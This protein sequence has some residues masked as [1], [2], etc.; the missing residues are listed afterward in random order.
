[1]GHL[2]LTQQLMA[3]TYPSL[4]LSHAAALKA[5]AAGIAKATAMNQPQCITVVDE[6][7]NL[8]AAVRMDGAKF[9]SI[10]SSHKKAVSAAASRAPTGPRGE[11]EVE[12]KLAIATGGRNLTLK[13]AVPILING[14]C[15]GAVGVGSGTGEQDREV[16]LAAVASIEG[17][18]TDFVFK[19]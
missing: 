1:M 3:D 11:P 7:G 5:L 13:G 19:D 6:G 18:K 10:D 14:I 8:L 15:V 16:A 9:V 12:L 2:S 4:K 17:A